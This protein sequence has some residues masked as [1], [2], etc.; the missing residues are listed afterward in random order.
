MRDYYDFVGNMYDPTKSDKVVYE[1]TERSISEIGYKWDM[2][3]ERYY[4]ADN[5]HVGFIWFCG[6]FYPI[7]F[8]NKSNLNRL[9]Y[10]TKKQ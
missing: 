10:Y 2:F 9:Q 3:S 4:G 6:K 8:A 7:Y 1:R 5:Y